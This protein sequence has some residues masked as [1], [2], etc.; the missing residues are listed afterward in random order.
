MNSQIR[1]VIFILNQQMLNLNNFMIVLM[2]ECFEKQHEQTT[3]MKKKLNDFLKNKIIFIMIS[4]KRQKLLNAAT[5]TTIFIFINSRL[6][7]I[8]THSEL[9]NFSSSIVLFFTS[10]FFTSSSN[11]AAS[12]SSIIYFLNRN[13]HIVIDLFKKWIIGLD[14]DPSIVSMND[15]YDAEW[16]K[17]WQDK[18][19][20]FYSKRLII[21]KHIYEQANGGSVQTV[22]NLIKTERAFKKTS[23]N[24]LS[25]QLRKGLKK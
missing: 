23:L 10:L 19:R 2:I 15:R 11:K 16:R 25:K 7:F 4:I 20:E 21:I 24:A 18:E 3:K 12:F 22:M 5:A 9:Q 17:E 6:Q 1:T 13:V 8:S 14:T